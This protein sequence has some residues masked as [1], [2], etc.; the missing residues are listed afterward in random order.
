VSTPFSVPIGSRIP[1]S[2]S[3]FQLSEREWDKFINII[4]EGFVVPVIGQELLIADQDG[5]SEPLY[6]VWGRALAEQA[7]LALQERDDSPVLYQVTNQLSQSQNSNDLAIDVDYVI[8]R[9]PW[10]VPE[11][12]RKLAQI[13]SFSLYVTTTVDHLMKGA[14]DEFRPEWKG[15]Q[16][17]IGFALHGDKSRNDLPDDFDY[18]SAPALF[19]LFGAT[20]PFPNS[21]AKTE[22]DLIDFSASLLDPHYAPE[23][24]YD[25]LQK[26]TVL[27]LGCSFPDWLGRFFI[28]A[29]NANRDVETINIYYV[30]ARRELGLENYLRRKR[31][32]VLAPVSPVAFVEELFRRWQERQVGSQASPGA[33]A[34]GSAPALKRGAVFLSYASED[35]ATVARIRAQLE[36]ANIDTWM[37]ESGLEPGVDYQYVIRENIRNASFF[38]AF[39][40]QSLS[41]KGERFLFR[42]WKWAEDAN[43]ERRKDQRFLQP[44]VIDN[45]PPGA[46]FVDPPYRDLQ[47]A[48]SRDGQLAPEFIQFLSQGI[49][50][51]RRGK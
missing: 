6:D 7:G 34:P 51:F 43:L 36:A 16:Q 37:D 20:S 47:W 10:P 45:T 4:L 32:K 9:Q 5:Q 40:S 30:S 39:I 27:L 49:R 12:L 35:R 21:F 46:S 33:P 11:S 42:E 48:K 13:R 18:Q 3:G 41:S 2:A 29:L 23:R 26:K 31:A 38:L 24:F 44:V 19:H 8:R 14:L 17:D 50:S 1:S 28:R 25:Y 22:D 15:L